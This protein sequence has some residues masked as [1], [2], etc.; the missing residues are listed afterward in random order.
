MTAAFSRREALLLVPAVVVG[1]ALLFAGPLFGE[2][3]TLSMGPDDP[4]MGL[5]PWAQGDPRLLAAVNPITPDVETFVLPGIMRA[6][7]LEEAEGSA[8]WDSTQLLGYPFAANMPWPL[9]GPVTWLGPRELQS[10][11]G[12]VIDPTT[13]LD[14]M[15]VLHLGIA[16]LLAYRCCRKLQ[17]DPAF[18][19]AGALAF[20]FSSWISTRW[21]AP[22]IVYTTVWWPGQL[23]A[24]IWIGR[25]FVRRGLVEGAVFTALMLL[26]G[27][28]QA[29][30]VLTGLTVFLALFDPDVRR[31]KRLAAVGLMALVGVGLAAPGLVLNQGAFA[32]SLRADPMVQA[33]TAS[34]GLP[35]PS[36]LGAVLPDAFGHPPDFSVA[37]APHP[38]MEGWLPQRLWW[39]HEIQNT[40]IEN[41]LY[42]G[43]FLLLLLGLIGRRQVDGRAR[44]LVL[45]AGL[46]VAGAVFGPELTGRWPA[47][48]KLA[49]GNVKRALV[50]VG[51]TLPFAGALLLQAAGSGRVRLPWAWAGALAVAIVGAPLFALTIDD[52]DASTW[53]AMLG[54]QALRQG[55]LL[56][57]SVLVLA[58]VARLGRWLPGGASDE[59]ASPRSA[60][61][62]NSPTA[63]SLLAWRLKDLAFAARW[64]RWLPALL[65]GMDL[66]SRAVA[67]N[68]FPP[69]REA[70]GA[71]PAIEQLAAR[72]GRVCVYGDWPGL[73]A[74][75][76]AS[77][78]GIRSLHGVAPLM[79]TTTAELLNTIEGPLL[80]MRDPRIVAPFREV[81][82]LSHPLLDLLA[83]AT[84]VHRDPELTAAS[85]LPTVFE[86]PEEGL[87]ALDRPSA[88][89]RAF[90]SG[91]ARVVADKDERLALLGSREF[92]GHA[93]VLLEKPLPTALP[94][95]SP[96]PIVAAAISAGEQRV[97]VTVNAPAPGLLVL[98]DAYAKGWYAETADGSR[99]LTLHR[100]HHA[101]RAVEVDAGEQTV[102]FRYTPP[103]RNHAVIVSMVLLMLVMA[104]GLSVVNDVLKKHTPAGKAAA[105]EARLKELRE[106][107]EPDARSD[108]DGT[109]GDDSGSDDDAWK[110]MPEG[111]FPPAI[112]RM[113]HDL[114]RFEG[115]ALTVII[116]AYDDTPQLRRTIWSIAQ[117]ADLPYQ[118]VVARA[119]QCVAKNRNLGLASAKCDLIVFMDD[120]VILPPG[121]MSKLVAVLAQRDDLGAVSAHLT[122]ADGSP[123]TRRPDLAPGE[124]WEIPIPG[125]CFV[126]SRERI[127]GA[128]FDENYQGSQWEDTDF[129]WQL[130]KMGL[131][132]GVTGDV[133]IV[134]DHNDSEN[135]WLVQNGEYFRG[136]WDELPSDADTFSISPEGYAA[137]KAGGVPGDV[138][139]PDDAAEAG[140]AKEWDARVA[141]EERDS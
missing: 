37:G 138:G 35:L 87:A 62:A 83:V 41:A 103:G 5:I 135:R 121:W 19:V 8:T 84:V 119:K 98:T 7:Q 33:E 68:P 127:T 88:G 3:S 12:V 110:D 139:E 79:L 94:E 104:L 10:L 9:D 111:Y 109:P 73:L 75:T 24:L 28:P 45:C 126:F 4:R 80:D 20:A 63:L 2:S 99:R 18:A 120:D 81:Q 108:G 112:P 122:F 137:W 64:V 92:D 17:V 31:L 22:H 133:V 131:K 101:L 29:G 130:R 36:L 50:V 70:F 23:T 15:L 117:T 34:R 141:E 136:K 49:A 30:V 47:L 113:A 48:A 82:S 140:P 97:E 129:V 114:G 39:S 59:D 16:L 11:T 6:R 58:L 42:P 60:G 71:T 57:A 53:S 91:G 61:F 128:Y 115:Q 27:F 132:T 124:F 51:V 74:P 89:P 95:V 72:D 105:R 14:I 25:G 26:S 107:G 21:H 13:L 32:D 67:F 118:L 90:W 40:V 65:I 66:V 56:A 52:P 93:T 44:V 116:P 96:Q 76:A 100:V 46:A 102:V 38:T 55:A 1:L 85:G 134:H 78:H 125:T 123:Q 106:G 69:Q 77:L 43:V 86:S 54:S